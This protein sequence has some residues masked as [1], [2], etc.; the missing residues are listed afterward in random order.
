MPAMV[1]LYRR[2]EPSFSWLS[3]IRSRFL[4]S[5]RTS[6]SKPGASYDPTT[7]FYPS[8]GKIKAGSH[9]RDNG[10]LELNNNPHAETFELGPLSMKVVDPALVRN[11]IEYGHAN[12]KW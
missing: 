8:N 10:Y 4:E 7:G 2:K 9:T 6:R 3:S 5:I 12:N 1:S 11:N